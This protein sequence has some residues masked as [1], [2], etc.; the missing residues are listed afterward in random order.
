MT[1]YFALFGLQRRPLIDLESLRELYFRK[2]EQ[3]NR[4]DPG[5]LATINEAFRVLS[6]PTLRLGHL[7]KLEFSEVPARQINPSFGALFGELANAVADFDRA[8]L[9]AGSQSSPL[10]RAVHFQETSSLQQKLFSLGAALS[11]QRTSL[12]GRINAL[13]EK[14]PDR[15]VETRDALAQIALDL[16]FIERWQQQLKER[17]LRLEELA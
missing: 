1:D 8:F 3:A 13:D 12:E 15:T 10:L 6:S 2:S 11:E 14:W 5:D 16:T 17:S 7:L 4:G 9:K